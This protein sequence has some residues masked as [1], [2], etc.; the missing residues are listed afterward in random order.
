MRGA[1]LTSIVT[2]LFAIFITSYLVN[3]SQGQLADDLPFDKLIEREGISLHIPYDWKELATEN[4]NQIIRISS[5]DGYSFITI[6]RYD[7]G[8]INE[9]LTKRVNEFVK[10]L[11]GI[12]FYNIEV[13]SDPFESRTIQSQYVI[14]GGSLNEEDNNS[15]LLHYEKGYIMNNHPLMITIYFAGLDESYYN[16][17]PTADN[18]IES[19]KIDPQAFG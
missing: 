4:E 8:P 6:N 13:N 12:E 17:S 7:S 1:I 16:N 19:L 10:Y 15:K 14:Q 18:I 5:P 9:V 11:P 3:N 2:V